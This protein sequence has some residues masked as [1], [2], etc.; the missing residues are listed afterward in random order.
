[1]SAAFTKVTAD[2]RDTYR[3]LRAGMVVVIV[4]LVAAIVID[5]L[6]TGCWQESISAYYY[7]AA[8]NVF[9]ADT[10]LPWHH[11]DRLQGQQRHRG[12]AAEFGGL[13]RIFRRV[14][15]VKTPRPGHCGQVSPTAGERLA[16]IDN[17][18]GAVIVGLV[19]A[20]AIIA[21]VYFVDKQSRC[22]TSD[23]GN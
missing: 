12:R 9:V 11:A 15:P 6:P 16:A 21:F 8:R 23:W 19:V 3:Y 18:I 20:G 22:D 17:N 13:A 1:M 7:T 14:C 5:S 4:M 2:G 10:L